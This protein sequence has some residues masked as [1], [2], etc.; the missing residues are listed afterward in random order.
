MF[1]LVLKKDLFFTLIFWEYL[2]FVRFLLILYY[3]SY[4]TC[5]SAKVTLISSRFGDVG[6]FL[7][8]A[9]FL[10]G[11]SERLKFLLIVSLVLVIITK[12]AV[13]PFSS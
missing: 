4:D 6:L 2:G 11:L 13:M 7:V 5:Y 10:K 1:I 9:F 8:I 12:R 3:G